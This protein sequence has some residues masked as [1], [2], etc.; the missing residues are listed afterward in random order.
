MLPLLIGSIATSVVAK[1]VS[2]YL[3]DGI[4]N[5]YQAKRL[6]IQQ[7]ASYEI[8]EIEY[9]SREI[10]LDMLSDAQNDAWEEINL[11][12]KNYPKIKKQ[13][14][15]A[16][17]HSNH[18]KDFISKQTNT[19]F[20]LSL[21]AYQEILRAR[22]FFWHTLVKK[23]ST[24]KYDI[25]TSSLRKRKIL[26]KN[27]FNIPDPEH[28]VQNIPRKGFFCN[29]YV[30]N[31]SSQ[32]IR[33]LCKN[34]INLGNKPF[35]CS[36]S[37]DHYP[38]STAKWSKGSTYQTFVTSVNYFDRK[39]EV[40]IPL[41]NLINS[42]SKSDY[43]FE[44]YPEPILKNNRLVGYCLTKKGNTFFLPKSMTKSRIKLNRRVEVILIKENFDPFN[45]IV[46]I[47]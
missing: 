46:K 16:R 12:R 43:I 8:Q 23:Y 28:F 13:L 45:L 47:N 22:E 37:L 38:P 10:I 15:I 26:R 2:E 3:S 18:F 6:R 44:S 9:Q 31:I 17:K 1:I 33:L 40:S 32:T 29:S 7:R 5:N 41:T 21:S 4:E 25:I 27:F 20:R 35:R 30:E 36:L 19:D 39:Y 42:I 34:P 24:K 14:N 11:I